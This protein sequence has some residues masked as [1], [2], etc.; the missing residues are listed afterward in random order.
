MNEEREGVTRNEISGG[1]V[2]GPVV[3]A[4]SIHGGVTFQVQASPAPSARVVPD[5]VPPL[6]VPFVSRG[7]DLALLDTFVPVDASSIG[8]VGLH[9]LPGVGKTATVSHWAESRRASFPDGQ[10]YIDYAEYRTAAGGGDVSEA[11]RHALVSLGVAESSIPQVLAE[12][13]K[14]FRSRSGPHRLLVVLDNVSD[15]AQVTPLVPK[16]RGSAVLVASAGRLG[17]LVLDGARFVPLEP[18]DDASALRL[19]E[20]RCGEA[21]IAADPDAVARVVAACGGLPVALHLVAARLLVTPGLT[22]ARLADELADERTRLAGLTLRE[23]SVSAV[24][25]LTYRDLPETA[26]RLYRRLG[27]IP[28]RSFDLG[29]AAVAAGQ[30][31]GATATAMEILRDNGLVERNPDDRWHLHDLVRLYARER[32]AEEETGEERAAGVRRIAGHYLLLTVLADRAIRLDRYRTPALAELEITA[33]DPFTGD[34]AVSPL[35]W[36]EAERENILAVLRDASAEGLHTEVWQAAE[37]FTAL[38]LHHRHVTMWKE[39]LELGAASASAAVAPAAEARLRSLLSRPLTDLGQ[40]DAA[41]RQL[42]IAIACADVSGLPVLRGSVQEFS[43]RDWERT[44]LPR[45]MEAYRRSA[46]LHTEGGVPRGAALGMYFLGCAQDKGGDH[47]DALES[48]RHAHRMLTDVNDPRMAARA[49][50]AIGLAHDHLGRSAE[51]VR[52]LTE[53]ADVLHEL[54][55]THY[56]AQ[57]HEALAGLAECTGDAAEAVRGHLVRALEIYEAAD[58]PAAEGIRRRLAELDGTPGA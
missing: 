23:R 29:V 32:A 3:Q 21:A 28:G 47:T 50:L 37:S 19:L 7:A 2:S 56:E 30:D 26:A 36:L 57:A 18:L 42:D 45:A 58:H 20:S 46:E 15:P 31:V 49:R 9:G 34:A 11:V 13:T 33:P 41:R 12:R 24:L 39:S 6:T 40:H 52:E 10:I 14:L 27:W 4:H 22:M 43:G 54:D 51:A 17:E 8:L 44:D 53:A 16:G 55:A 38:F 48:L 25:G 35:G 1:V 5:E